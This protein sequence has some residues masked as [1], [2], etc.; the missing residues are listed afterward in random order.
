MWI[1]QVWAISRSYMKL[2]PIIAMVSHGIL[3]KLIG[4]TCVLFT[5]L[6]FV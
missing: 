6:H 4:F 5:I 3:V 2:G 1:T